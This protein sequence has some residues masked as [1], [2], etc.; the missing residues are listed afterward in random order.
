MKRNIKSGVT[1]I[2]LLIVIGIISV[3]SVVIVTIINPAESAR[4]SR[5]AKRMSDLATI[6]RAID[7][8][9]ADKQ[10]L[11]DTS[12]VEI[13]STNIGGLELEKYLPAIP[14]DPSR[15]SGVG[16]RVAKFDGGECNNL[17][18]AESPMMYEIVCDDGDYAIRARFE[19]ES[20]CNALKEDGHVNDYYEMGT[21]LD[22]FGP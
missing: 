13:T 11:V 8:A 9:L 21:K 2:E 14:K 3:L 4:K 19:S 20:S 15:N 17:N 10:K 16:I 1:L 5:D 22:L 6:K 12:A 18:S 7:L